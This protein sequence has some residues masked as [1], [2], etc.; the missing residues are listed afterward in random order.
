Y[1]YADHRY[2][3]SFPT[4]RSS[5]LDIDVNCRRC[6]LALGSVR[7][8]PAEYFGLNLRA[9]ELLRHVPLY[10]VSMVDLPGGGGGRSIA[11]VRALDSTAPPSRIASA[12]Y[13]IRLL[14]G[15]LFRW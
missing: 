7:V 15:Q 2:L 11:D 14:L 4:R 10:D 9:H 13:G 1:S 6:K 3:H 8:S 5:D 12:L